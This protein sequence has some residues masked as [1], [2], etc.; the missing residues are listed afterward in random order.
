MNKMWKL[1]TFENKKIPCVVAAERSE[2]HSRRKGG[3]SRYRSNLES[4]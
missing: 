1:G 2:K 3:R 4:L